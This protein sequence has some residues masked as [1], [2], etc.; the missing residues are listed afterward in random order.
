MLKE[1]KAKEME[2]AEAEVEVVMDTMDQHP[3]N[4]NSSNNQGKAAKVCQ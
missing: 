4:H 2:A 3:Q 1:R